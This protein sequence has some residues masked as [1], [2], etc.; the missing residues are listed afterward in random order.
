MEKE[1]IPPHAKCV[2]Q[3]VLFDVYQWEQEL[4]DGS[5]TTFEKIRRRDSVIVVPVLPNGNLLLAEDDQ[6]GR[7]PILTFPAGQTEEGE[8]LTVAALR[9]LLEE[10]GYQ[11]EEL[12]LWKSVQPLAKLDWHLHIYIGRNC[13]KVAEPINDPGER[14]TV[15]EIT[16]DELLTL[17]DHPNF[18]NGE[19][20]VELTKARYDAGERALLEKKL[21]G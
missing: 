15:Q 3:G 18:Q 9:E 8:D 19:L 20:E 5:I 10:T 16:F 7:N 14:I 17:T 6:P 13:V 4:F 12:I 21:F 1:I 11:P 2:F